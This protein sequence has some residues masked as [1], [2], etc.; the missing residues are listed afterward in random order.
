MKTD[1]KYIEKAFVVL[2]N[3]NNGIIE[4]NK[5]IDGKYK[6]YIASFGASVI[7]SGIIPTVLMYCDKSDDKIKV[8]KIL[9]KM[10]DESFDLIN[11]K[12]W[13][14]YVNVYSKKGQDTRSELTEAAT[15]LKLAIRTYP[16]KEEKGKCNEQ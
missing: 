8:L 13:D 11:D 12:P 4:N 2:G 3:D 5:L 16:V 9:M 1:N 15:A 14:F 10:V 6:G 7:I